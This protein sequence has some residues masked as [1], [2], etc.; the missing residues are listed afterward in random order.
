MEIKN[1][2]WEQVSPFNKKMF[3]T[4]IVA[5][6]FLN[7]LI[8]VVPIYSL[9]VFD[10]VLTSRS[11]DTLF[12][13]SL[14]VLFL[15]I[16]QSALDIQ[17][18]RYLHK[19]SA[20]LDALA[21]SYLYQNQS[22]AMGKDTASQ[23][24][25][26]EIKTFIISPALSNAFDMIWA[27]LF[28]L[29]MFSLHPIVGFVG[30]SAVL[31]VAGFSVYIY[32]SKTKQ[33]SDSQHAVSACRFATEQA[34]I[35]RDNIKTQH[36]ASGLNQQFQHMTAERVWYDQ[37]LGLTSST[38][39][40]I[41]KCLRF[42][43]QMMIM[44]VGAWL[45]IENSMSAG[46]IIAGSILM[47]RVLQPFEQLA[48]TMQAWR[49]AHAAN[50]RVSA[51]FR[52]Q[53]DINNTTQFN[54]IKGSLHIDNLSWFPPKAKLP[55]LKNIRLKLEPGNRV[56]VMGANGSGKTALCQLIAG[57]YQPSSGTVRIDAASLPQWDANQLKYVVGYVPQK[58]EF[59]PGSI[60]QNIAHFDTNMSD[61]DV[62]AAAKAIG[63]HTDIAHLEHG[64]NTPI[65][66]TGTPI[67]MGLAQAIAI[68]RALYYQPKLLILD[69]A[70]SHLDSIRLDAFKQ[71]LIQK[72]QQG[73]GVVMIA[74]QRE[75]IAY[76]DWLVTLDNGEITTAQKAE[77]IMTS[78]TTKV[79]E[80][81][82]AVS[83]G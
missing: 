48:T 35:Q 68:A 54:D 31:A 37:Q 36:L 81:K 29:V 8:L 55:L 34:T 5:G 79:R 28:L 71:L 7:A 13:I 57:L 44:A 76:V 42:V 49:N 64:Y 46:G 30:L 69:E 75:L 52:H 24:D 41:A 73:C 9:Q 78:Q 53:V 51:Y 50:T 61:N 43:L 56:M 25:I 80:I 18:N 26:R 62:I 3:S 72:K 77:Q 1:L 65:G 58:I 63:I 67:S 22:T 70:N 6:F 32:A 16:I 21:S 17:K 74:H 39:A 40:S 12:L 4:L 83:H 33:N 20:K 47:S 60:K 27:P 15:L 11:L 66:P 23:Q 82:P 38:L 59:L 19:K 10:R 14:I 2:D 45:V